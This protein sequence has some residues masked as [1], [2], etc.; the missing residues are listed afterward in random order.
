MVLIII[1]NLKKIK[2]LK[3]KKIN[4]KSPFLMDLNLK[5]QNHLKISTEKD[6][7]SILKSSPEKECSSINELVKQ[8]VEKINTLFQ[9]QKLID[10]NLKSNKSSI[11]LKNRKKFRENLNFHSLNSNEDINKDNTNTIKND[12]EISENSIQDINSFSIVDTS[13]LRRNVKEHSFDFKHLLKPKKESKNQI[14]YIQNSNQNE[15]K[16]VIQGIKSYET[17]FKPKKIIDLQKNNNN[18]TPLKAKKEFL[19]KSEKKYQIEPNNVNT[20]QKR[21]NIYYSFYRKRDNNNNNNKINSKNNNKVQINLD[22]INSIKA[23]NSKKYFDDNYKK[24]F[25]SKKEDNKNEI[26]NSLRKND[27]VDNS[28]KKSFKFNF[29]NIRVQNINQIR[30]YASPSSLKE[31]KKLEKSKTQNRFINISNSQALKQFYSKEFPKKIKTNDILKLMFFLNEYIINLNLLDDYYLKK[32][33]KILNDYSKFLASK[34][35]INY[36]NESDII[37][38]DF[39]NKTKIIQRNWRKLK[40][41]KYIEKNRF[42]KEKEIKNMIISN[43]IEKAGY[44]IKKFFGLFHN[45]IEQFILLDNKDD[46]NINKSN[47]NRCFNFLVKIL[48]NNLSN[49]EKNELYRDYINKVIYKN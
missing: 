40:V 23:K 28:I 7:N 15:K 29:T 16:Y 14:D 32:N 12:D 11:N 42:D 27:K 8:S 34:I 48:T 33:R 36:P 10:L 43:Y 31:K 49:Y 25:T 46:F 6:Y 41:E 24:A 3:M 45:L 4:I 17:L 26:F 38:D 1:I 44:K 2:N 30:I 18:Y 37:V 22:L 20:S 39:V 21:R 19:F 47:I 35:K 13:A 5:R 9:H